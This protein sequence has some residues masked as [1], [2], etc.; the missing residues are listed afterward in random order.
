MLKDPSVCHTLLDT[1]GPYEK[2]EQCV[3][4]A[5]EIAV[6]LPEHMPE[7]IA[8]NYKCTLKGKGI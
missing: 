2:E 3:R 4:R 5:Y 7:F 6:K 1:Q 8:T